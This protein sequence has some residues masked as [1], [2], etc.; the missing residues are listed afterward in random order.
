MDKSRSWA[1]QRRWMKADDG[2]DGWWPWPELTLMLEVE[3]QKFTGGV[4]EE[5]RLAHKMKRGLKH[6]SWA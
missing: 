6:G 4:K 1:P 5:G 2:L 3:P